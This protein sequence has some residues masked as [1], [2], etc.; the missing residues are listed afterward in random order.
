MVKKILRIHTTFSQGG[1][2]RT[3][4]TLHNALNRTP[5]LLS[6]FAYGRG[7]KVKNERTFKFAFFPEVYF[8]AFLTRFIGLEGFGMWFSTKRLINYIKNNNF[9]LIHLH[10]LHGYYLNLSFINW[11]KKNKIPIIWTLHDEWPITGRCTHPFDCD[12]WEKGCGKCPD[13]SLYPKTYF[14]DFSALMWKRKKEVFS[15]GWNPILVC[16]SQWLADR[17]GE[18]Y[19][20][21]YQ[22]EVIPNG[23]DTELFKPKDKIEA[24]KKLGMPLSKKVILFVAPK[25]KDEQKGAKFF[26]ETL[27][28]VKTKDW[29]AITLGKKIDLNGKL[30]KNINIKQL[31]YISDPELVAEAYNVAD[32]FCITSLDETFGRTVAESMACGTPVVGFKTGGVSEQ[33]SNDCGILVEPKNIK[34]LAEAINK[35]LNNNEKRKRLS[36]NCRKRALENYS[37]EKFKERYIDLYKKI[38]K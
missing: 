14:F 25:L 7:P 3:A 4:Q 36:L 34:D 19:L 8:Q 22:I 10:N 12:R 30:Q 33:V 29:M 21:R 20:N 6:Y 1:A 16:P 35:L 27:K 11:L 15:E 5:G 26:F 17:V 31:G 2:A 32:I 24:R 38:L 18:S 9:D 13:L 23:I 28:Y 37:V